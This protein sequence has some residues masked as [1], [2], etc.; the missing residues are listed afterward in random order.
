MSILYLGEGEGSCSCVHR[1]FGKF[2]IECA[3]PA[4]V[5]AGLKRT[6]IEDISIIKAC[7]EELFV[8]LCT[9]AFL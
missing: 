3:G 4:V 1:D 6:V 2:A 5:Y 8:Y 7:F 9:T